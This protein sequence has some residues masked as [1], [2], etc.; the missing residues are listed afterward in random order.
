MPTQADC[1]PSTVRRIA[2]ICTGIEEGRDGVGDYCRRLALGLRTLGADCTLLALNDRLIQREILTE[3]SELSPRSL[4]LPENM[5]H[6]EK[7]ATAARFLADSRPD[8][9]SLQ[10][11][12]Y[13][14]NRKGLVL[15]ELFWLPRLLRNYR[16][17]VMLHELWVGLGVFHSAKNIGLGTIQRRLLVQLLRRLEPAVVD[18][19]NAFYHQVG[20]R[21]GIRAGILPLFGNIPVTTNT[22][23]AWLSDLIVRSGGPD[24]RHDR[25]SCWIFGLFGSILP[26]WPAEPLLSRLE[27][28]GKRAQRR[29]VVVA[30]GHLSRYE[31]DLFERRA[32][33]FPSIHF[34]H[35]GPRT[36]A[37]TS[38]FL[39]SMDFGLTSHP[40]YLLGKSGSTAAMLEHGLPVIASWG[41]IAPE[42]CPVDLRLAPLIWRDD[43]TLEAKLMTPPPRLRYPARCLEAARTLL[44]QLAQTTPPVAGRNEG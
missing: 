5:P 40:L 37:E 28:I 16:R 15:R 4:R 7:L 18:T 1:A 2:L 10:F 24:L 14:F 36:T 34:T 30:V 35:A 9:V 42:L 21:A 22:A 26:R 38:Q 27:A 44:T 20:I 19:T 17:H 29:I 23:D 43:E 3:A 39:N 13:G 41:D 32:R 25:Q 6:R 12:C 8:W 31:L 33:A 11:V